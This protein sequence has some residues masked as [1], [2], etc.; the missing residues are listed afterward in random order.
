MAQISII[1]KSD[2]AEAKRFDAEYFK[3]EYLEIEKIFQRIGYEYLK[4]YCNSIKKGIFDLNPLNYQNK[5]IPFIR[6][7]EI[8]DPFIDFSSTVFISEQIHNKNN[9][10][11]LLHGDLVFTKIGAF[12]G[13]VS[14]LPYNYEKYNFSQNVTGLSI[15]QDII[16]SG[17][18][19]VYL[20]SKYG[21]NQILR[22]TMLSGQGKLELEDIRKL[23]IVNCNIN[24]KKQIHSM[25]LN[26]EKVK[27]KSKQLYREAEEILLN[28]LGLLNYTQKNIL[29]F[30]VRKKDICAAERFD[31]DYFQPKYSDIIS[32][33]VNY[34]NGW[35]EAKNVIIFND[36]NYFPSA[37]KK[38][39]YLALANISSQGYI[40]DYQMDFGENLPS[41]ARRK[42]NKD[43]VL[44]SSIEGSL[45]SCAL[46]DEEF[47]NAICSTGFFVIRSNVIN[48]ETLLILF[49]TFLFQDLLIR[50]SKGT[51]LT[52]I[53]K[54]EIEKFKIPIISQEIQTQIK[55]KI[56]ASFTARKESKKLLEQ[57]KTMV[58]Q[59]IE[60]DAKNQ[61]R[62]N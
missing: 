53:S 54:S 6:T 13:D 16:E 20:L 28:E 34:K 36:K 8:K 11:E 7:S 32:K 43:D 40:Q 25:V 33:I 5:G 2:I 37:N 9:K 47:N 29:T 44:I 30:E 18:L 10:T 23:K 42:I 12:I 49:K 59:E 48:S 19:L 39:K 60:S 61:M 1:K 46:V 56:E 15:K 38:Y 57:A 22:K 17:F 55:E 41:R 27:E 45:S 62:P 35:D 24:L 51:I 3:P 14:M 31:S 4:K 21:K 52:A 26:A 58:E 50:G